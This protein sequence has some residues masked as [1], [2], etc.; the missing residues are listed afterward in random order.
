MRVLITTTS[1]LG[2]VLPMV[3]LA[4]A[5]QARGHDVL[6]ATSAETCDWV[7]EAGISARPAGMALK[8]RQQEFWRRNPEARSLPPE[9]VPEIMFQAMFGA[10][11]A[12][13]MLVE[14]LPFALDWAPDL[15]VHDA[16]EFA[17][18]I[19]AALAGVPN[20]V[21]SFGGLSPRATGGCCG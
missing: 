9:K 4:R 19:V 5:V 8:D 2:H 20:V 11:A 17:G 1:G 10:I 14:L 13:A 12:P 18:P 6:W 15:V 21:K 7:E 16:A 3:P